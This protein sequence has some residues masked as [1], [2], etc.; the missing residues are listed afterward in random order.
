MSR[1]ACKK[2][3]MGCV[4][5][6]WGAIFAKLFFATHPSASLAIILVGLAISGWRAVSAAEQR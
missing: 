5:S 3:L 2:F 1:T 4:W 6:V